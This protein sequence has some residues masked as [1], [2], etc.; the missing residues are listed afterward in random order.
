M[1]DLIQGEGPAAPGRIV[2]F[3]SYKGGVG[4]SMLLA[5]VG[6]LLARWNRRI[7]LIDFD[8]EAPGLDQFFRSF[9]SG[10]LRSTPGIVDMLGAVA[11][12]ESPNWR[13]FVTKVKLPEGRVLDLLHAGRNDESYAQAL[14]GLN[15]ERMFKEQELGRFLE[16]WRNDMIGAS[17]YDY[18]LVDSRTGITDIGGI[19]TI[20]LPDVIV[21]LVT[22]TSQSLAGLRDALDGA[23][24]GHAVFPSER[25]RLVILP[26]ASRDESANAYEKAVEWRRRFANDLGHLLW[27][28]PRNTSAESVFDWLRIPYET[29]WSFGE[30]LPVL[31]EEVEN[32][33]NLSFSYF[34]VAQLLDHGF[35]WSTVKS[36]AGSESEAVARKEKELRELHEAQLQKASATRKMRMTVAAGIAAV[37]TMAG[38]MYGSV[39]KSETARQEAENSMTLLRA[40]S[41][42]KEAELL[43]AREREE[44]QRAQRK[45]EEATLAYGEGHRLIST[46]DYEL[47]VK[48]FDAAIEL[49]PDQ[50]DFYRSRAVALDGL[51]RGSTSS[52]ERSELYSASL[53]D[54]V[55]WVD[56]APTPSRRIQVAGPAA[57]K[58][59]PDLAVEQARKLLIDLQKEPNSK[60]A[61]QMS[62][63]MDSVARSGGR[64]PVAS[65]ARAI[66]ENLRQAAAVNSVDISTKT[67]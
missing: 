47:A 62:T 7:L 11:R 22:T 9:I 51:A 23:A 34:Q 13:N 21:G 45:Q 54:F 48:S 29:Y 20:H 25:E 28:R 50:S 39:Y 10:S 56:L 65:E 18:V 55:K 44:T 59:R 30:C 24:A 14:A 46:R 42:A 52:T 53:E 16:N 35:D 49:S 61:L 2:T 64:S 15:W 63:I 40:Q 27:W 37:F 67:P 36:R 12:D 41:E 4:R 33:K 31:E 60:V 17:G 66:G 38:V 8:L 19:C 58:G 3:Y 1:S 43:L 5:N 6:A 32:P 26:I 57:G